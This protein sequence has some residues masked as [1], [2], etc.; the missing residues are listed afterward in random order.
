MIKFFWNNLV[1]GAQITAT[2]TNAQFPLSNLKDPRRTKVYRSTSNSDSVTFDFGQTENID[3]V[4]AVGNPIDGIGFT[5]ASLD[6]GATS[7]FSPDLLSASLDISAKYN[8]GFKEFTQVSTRFFR[9]NLTSTAGYCELANLFVGK[10]L[11]LIDDK[12]I[13]FGWTHQEQELSRNSENPYGQVF[14]DLIG[15]RKVFNISFTNL[16]K[17]QLEQIDEM[18]DWT[19]LTRPFW[20]AIGCPDITNSLERFRGMV[21]LERKPTKTNTFF[22]RYGLSMT[23]REAR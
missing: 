3:S 6:A 2:T 4:F 9:V 10:S 14:S 18:T 16:T 1:D 20:V 7:V 12:S 23:L 5:A 19:G 11:T 8:E 21:Y 15:T 22:N 17:D 13:N